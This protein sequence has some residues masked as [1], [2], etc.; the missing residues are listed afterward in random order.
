MS[1][2]IAMK[3]KEGIA[4]EAVEGLRGL[5]F[6]ALVAALISSNYKD[7]VVGQDPVVQRLHHSATAGRRTMMDMLTGQ[8]PEKF[9]VDFRVYAI[10]AF[11]DEEGVRDMDL[12]LAEHPTLENHSVM[13]FCTSDMRPEVLENASNSSSCMAT[14]V[15]CNDDLDAILEALG[16]DLSNEPSQED[17]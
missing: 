13:A 7:K 16:T 12:Y 2:T 15:Y 14:L 17:M 1:I 4:I 3:C 11:E 8:G 6:P 9:E 10:G 5:G